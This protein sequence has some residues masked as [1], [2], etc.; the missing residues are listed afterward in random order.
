MSIEVLS[1][2]LSVLLSVSMDL[3]K[4]VH[5]T[6]TMYRVFTEHNRV[7][8]IYSLC[9]S[10][11][12]CILKLSIKP[13]YFLCSVSTCF[14]TLFLL[15]GIRARGLRTFATDIAWKENLQLKNRKNWMDRGM[16]SSLP[17]EK[18]NKTTTHLGL[19]RCTS[20]CSGMVTRAMSMEQMTQ[21]PNRHTEISRHWN[22]R[23]AEYC[24]VSRL[25]WANNSKSTF[26]IRKLRKMLGQI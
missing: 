14:R 1:V 26:G 16:A 24:I 13:A 7:F 22:N 12:L 25:V 18:L 8:C 20:T 19:T 17:T 21:H 15:H 6:H 3:Y 23:R 10:R 2:L 11:V 5:W 4:S 9:L